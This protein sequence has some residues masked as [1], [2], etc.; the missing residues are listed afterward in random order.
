MMI[1]VEK[2][3]KWFPLSV[4]VSLEP[5]SWDCLEK[6]PS[7]KHEHNLSQH[8]TITTQTENNQL[9]PPKTYLKPNTYILY[10]LGRRFFKCS[11]LIGQH[12]QSESLIGLFISKNQISESFAL[13][14]SIHW[15]ETDLINMSWHLSTWWTIMCN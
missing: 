2:V 7:A 14:K 8:T 5:V 11:P 3:V 6:C 1:K 9:L 13:I 15:Y 12:K 4:S 10:H